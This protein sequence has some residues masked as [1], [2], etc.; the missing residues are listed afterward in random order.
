M[1]EK[2][3]EFIIKYKQKFPNSRVNIVGEYINS[4]TKIESHCLDCKKIWYPI[5]S[6]LLKGC[7]CP[8]CRQKEQVK[9][10]TFTTQKFKD[11]YYS[12]YPNKIL[13]LGEYINAKTKIECQ[14]MQCKTPLEMTPDNLMRGRGCYKCSNN[15]GVKKTTKEF[16][17]ELYNK[18]PNSSVII[19][20]KYT[21]AKTSIK[22]QCK[23]CNHIWKTT[24]SSLLR[25]SGCHKCTG[26]IAKTT[27]EFKKDYYDK[28]PN[29]TISIIGSYKKECEPIKCRCKVCNNEWNTTTPHRLLNGVGCPKCSN[30]KGNNLIKDILDKNNIEYIE[31]MKFKDCK[32]KD[33]LR[34]DFYL[35]KYNIIIEYDG[36]QH[37]TS[38]SF[39]GGEQG[40]NQRKKYDN[41]KNDYCKNND[42]LLLRI[43]YKYKPLKHK[44]KIENFILSIIETRIIPKEIIQFYNKYDYSNYL[45]AT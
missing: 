41:I 30:S 24:P 25:G 28:F 32:K 20:G 12:K 36:E 14:C 6:N 4:K 9:K 40:F 5:P 31:E 23:N 10:R 29:S 45:K 1:N 35:P 44:R 27:E 21:G 33:F 13:I 38:T 43:P 7:G 39:Y 22:C 3:N 26:H 11:K 42:I 37:F 15:S 34:Y 19:I 18:F 16:K 8:D 17:E 2:T